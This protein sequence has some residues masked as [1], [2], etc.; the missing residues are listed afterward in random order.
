[1]MRAAY[2]FREEPTESDWAA[3][4]HYAGIVGW[5]HV[6]PYMRAEVHCLSTKLGFPPLVLDVMLS[7]HTS[8]LSVRR[9]GD[10][11]NPA[12]AKRE[13]KPR[14]ARVVRSRER[15][16]GGRTTKRR[17]PRRAKTKTQNRR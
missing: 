5:L 10:E 17:A 11:P 9:F 4:E 7:G 16:R 3:F 6:W 12:P 15:E 14:K 2:E 13:G 1:M 8:Q